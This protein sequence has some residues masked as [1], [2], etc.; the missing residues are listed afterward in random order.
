MIPKVTTSICIDL[1]SASTIHASMLLREGDLVEAQS[2]D[3]GGHRADFMSSFLVSIA[4]G[5]FTS[6]MCIEPL[7]G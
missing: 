6:V 2:D 7:S 1:H 4:V 5:I 3:V